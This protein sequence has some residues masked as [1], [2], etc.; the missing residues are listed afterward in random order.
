[1]ESCST[2]TKSQAN[3]STKTAGKRPAV[4]LFRQSSCKPERFRR[5]AIF[6]YLS[7]LSVGLAGAF[8]FG[9]ANGLVFF[10]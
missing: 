10:N 2:A 4:F 7:D 5:P 3:D 8:A 1:M 9:L 6:L